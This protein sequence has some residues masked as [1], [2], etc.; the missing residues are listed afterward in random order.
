MNGEQFASLQQAFLSA[1]VAIMLVGADGKIRFVNQQTN[2]LFGYSENAL[3]GADVEILVPGRLRAS[4]A[5]HHRNYFESPVDHPLGNGLP[6][7]G[8][9]R[10]GTD[11][12]IEVS[13]SP[14]ETAEG[15]LAVAAV[16]DT[17]DRRQVERSLR[18]EEESLSRLLESTRAVPWTAD[19]AKWQFTYIG[20][21]AVD[22]LGY[23]VDTWFE[24]DFWVDH[25][26]PDD[27]D[28]AIERSNISIAAG[29]SYESEYRMIAADGRSV[30]VHDLVNVVCDKRG[31]SQLRG[32]MIDITKQKEMEAQL[33]ESES[34][35]KISE[36]R[37]Q[38]LAGK[39]LS[40]QE[41]ERRRL[42][43]EIHDDLTQRL[44]G[45][46]SK[47]GLVQH[48]LASD[49]AGLYRQLGEIHD[50]LV[51]LSGDVHALSRA[52]HPSM[53]EHLGLED[54]I[55]WECESFT[56]RT[57][58]EVAFASS[59]IP[60]DLAKEIGICFY[61]IAQEALNNIARHAGTDRAAVSLASEGEELMLTIQDHGVGFDCKRQESEQGIGLQS[62]TERARLIDAELSIESVP[63]R[64]TT[65]RVRAPLSQTV[66]AP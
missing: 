10:D 4:H 1:P 66:A 25:I 15:L 36:Q 21:Q 20:P 60:T 27:R 9:H 3:L 59:E 34:A 8:L 17:S 45:L 62:M 40:A 11:F 64:G 12:P 58:I 26:H 61:R 30:W 39:L 63:G 29:Q 52:L 6:F 38:E 33:R 14:I 2:R 18:R 31:A 7:R 23:P 46:A 32:F 37:L 55:R 16:R 22:F 49:Q 13:V 47:T 5:E 42:A 35:L 57:S 19:V 50:Q 48:E 51:Q 54:A 56:A 24:T 28:L 53:L 41:D 43:R 44:A 65:V